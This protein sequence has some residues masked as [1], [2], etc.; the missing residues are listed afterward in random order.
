MGFM[1]DPGAFLRVLEHVLDITSYR[2][3]LLAA[4]YQPLEDAIQ[5]HAHGAS[6]GSEQTPCNDDGVFLFGGRVLSLPGSIPYTWLLP[7][8][9]AAIHHGGS[10]S[11]AAALLAGIP[12]VIC[13]FMLDQ[14]YWAERMFWLGVAAEPLKRELLVPHIT[15]GNGLEGAKMLA[16]AINFALASHVKARA[17]EFATALSTEDGVSEAVKNLKEELGGST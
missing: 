2:F 6:S 12:Q 1:K 11:T 14:F 16:N 17:S 4:G 9:A 7:R 15:D 13:P 8:C 3:I 5:L 10:G